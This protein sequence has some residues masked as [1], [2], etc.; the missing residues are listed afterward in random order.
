MFHCHARQK[1]APVRSARNLQPVQ[2]DSHLAYSVFAAGGDFFRSPQEPDLHIQ[3]IQFV[4]GDGREAGIVLG[5]PVGR[6]A[7]R[8]GQ[9]CAGTEITATGTQLAFPLKAHKRTVNRQIG[10][11]GKVGFKPVGPRHLD[12]GRHPAA[13][14]LKKPLLFVRA[15]F[16]LCALIVLIGCH[17]SASNIK[18]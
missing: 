15:K 6:I 13:R 8:L 2:A 4:G 3:K 17:V 1:Q 18:V 16:R 12:H 5:R 10:R 9:R 14:G 7:H 11:F